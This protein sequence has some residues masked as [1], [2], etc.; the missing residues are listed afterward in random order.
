[1]IRLRS[2]LL[3]TNASHLSSTYFSQVIGEQIPAIIFGKTDDPAKAVN[4]L[5]EK[6]KSAGY[7]KVKAEIQSQL[8]AFKKLMEG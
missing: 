3:R 1:M 5:R 2:G 8:D 7:E 6:L 4:D